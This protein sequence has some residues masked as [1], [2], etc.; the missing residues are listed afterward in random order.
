MR[1]VL[2]SGF[3]VLI[4]LI[5]SIENFT[6]F[7]DSKVKAA[8]SS[9]SETWISTPSDIEDTFVSSQFPTTNYSTSQ[10]LVVG[11][12]QTFATTRSFLKFTLPTLP[13]GAVVTSAKLSLYQYYNSTNQVTVDIKPINSSWSANTLNWNNKPSEGSSVSNAIV[14]KPSWKDF[15]SQTL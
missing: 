1:K 3:V 11:K 8:T 10:Y 13:K 12:H 14:D 4:V 7:K 15:L 6:I 2:F 9:L 5:S